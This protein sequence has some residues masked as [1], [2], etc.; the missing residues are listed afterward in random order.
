MFDFW[1]EGA[2]IASYVWRQTKR[3]NAAAGSAAPS[4]IQLQELRL[5]R[6]IFYSLFLLFPALTNVCVHGLNL[7]NLYNWVFAWVIFVG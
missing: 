3:E 5:P 6:S 2:T 7:F 4:K 1:I